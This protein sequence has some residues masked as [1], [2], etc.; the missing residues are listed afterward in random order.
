MVKVLLDAC[1]PHR[2]CRGLTGFDVE[3]A[4]SAGLDQNSDGALLA[5]IEGNYD[6]LVTRDR[7][8]TFQ[9]K[10][11][12]R[13]IAVVVLRS[14]DQSPAAFDALLPEL[15]VAISAAAPGNVTLVGGGA[16]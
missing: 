13:S 10:I 9:Q 15:R 6:V 2:L 7:N 1:V 14:I 4:Q 5:A 3:T 16:S 8:L 12:G 11:T